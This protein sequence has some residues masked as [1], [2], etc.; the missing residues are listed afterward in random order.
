MT[1]LVSQISILTQNEFKLKNI[2]VYI[3]NDWQV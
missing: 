3:A 1:T 2:C